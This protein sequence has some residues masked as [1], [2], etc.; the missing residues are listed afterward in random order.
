MKKKKFLRLLTVVLVLAMAAVA[1]IGSSLGKYVKTFTGE[2]KVSFSA[3]LA[4]ELILRETLAERQTN[5]GYLLK[6][7]TYSDENEYTLL[8]GLNVPKDPHVIISGKTDIPAY[9]FVE[10][11]ENFED[12]TSGQLSYELGENWLKVSDSGKD[13]R[14]VYVYADNGVAKVIDENIGSEPIYILKNNAFAVSQ[15]L[16]HA[17][18]GDVLTFHACLGETAMGDTPFEVYKAV[19]NMH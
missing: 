14:T 8:P 4:D 12:N 16:N 6:T 1:L 17:T 9:L 2:A 13:G 5:G 19:Y 10:V 11:K 7:G 15:K 18:S 3:E